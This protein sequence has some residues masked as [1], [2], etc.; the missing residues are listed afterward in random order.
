M[1]CDKYYQQNSAYSLKDSSTVHFRIA[2]DLAILSFAVAGKRKAYANKGMCGDQ[3]HQYPR[4]NGS[5]LLNA[6]I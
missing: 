4:N 5:A 2:F 3:Y 6:S 1:Q